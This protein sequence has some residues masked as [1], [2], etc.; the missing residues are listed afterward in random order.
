MTIKQRGD[1]ICRQNCIVSRRPPSTFLVNREI[2][3][4]RSR[5]T[6]ATAFT[7]L[8]LVLTARCGAF[9]TV[10]DNLLDAEADDYATGRILD[11]NGTRLADWSLRTSVS[12]TDFSNS[13]LT[14]GPLGLEYVMSNLVNGSAD[15]N[16]IQYA[17]SPL[18]SASLVNIS[19]SQSV[20]LSASTWNG[21]QIEPSQFQLLWMGGGTASLSDPDNQI[22]GF[23][24]GTKL[25]SGAILPFSDYRIFN[26]EDHWRVDLPAGASEVEVRWSSADPQA[27]S[28]LTLEWVSFETTVAVVPEAAS[29]SLIGLGLIIISMHAR[30]RLR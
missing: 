13:R 8:L 25:P 10:V 11:D 24:D 9:N 22:S 5:T 16:V 21:G 1:W 14:G 12:N 2:R 15:A 27:N 30:R 29:F 4:T 20:Y 23:A 19:I 17:V 26:D 18:Q 28:H 6:E 3:M 7:I